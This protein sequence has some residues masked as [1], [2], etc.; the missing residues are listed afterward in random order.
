MTEESL[1]RR[2]DQFNSGDFTL[3]EI[4]LVQNTGG[5][6][7]KQHGAKPGDLYVALTDEVLPGE[8]GLEII[9]VDFQKTRTYW[10]RTDISDEPPLCGSLDADSYVSQTNE[11]CHQCPHL[12]EAPWLLDAAKRREACLLNYN[13]L[14]FRVTD[15]MPLLIRASG[16]STQAARNLLTALRLNRRLQGHYEKALVHMTAVKKKTPSGDAF[17]FSFAVKGMVSDPEMVAEYRAQT[18]SLL[19]TQ[20]ALPGGGEHLALNE[21]QAEPAKAE[22]APA[23]AKPEP[24]V[25]E[26]VVEQKPPA[27]PVAPPPQAK[28]DLDF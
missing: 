6:F 25:I 18:A 24:K 3:P 19:G 11:D 12:N 7:A 15:L 16:I 20:I 9:V 8:V 1:T 5:D 10:G 28:I 27:T 22:I 21:G 14:C 13:I 4:K 23:T 2:M 17:A 26:G